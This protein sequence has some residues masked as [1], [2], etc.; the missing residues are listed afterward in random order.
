M[1]L[2]EYSWDE[3]IVTFITTQ[4]LHHAHTT[5]GFVRHVSTVVVKI[6]HPN[7]R[8]TTWV[9]T[10]ELI[11]CTGRWRSCTNQ[12]HYTSTVMLLLCNSKIWSSPI[13]VTDVGPGADPGVQVVLL[14]Y[15][16]PSPAVGC[17]YFPPGLQSP[18]QPKNVTVLWP[19]VIKLY[20]LMTEA[21]RCA[22]TTCTRL[23][24]GT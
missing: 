23:F 21:Y 17:H 11:R 20:C 6:T 15:F 19:V 13:L 8:Y 5:V 12:H 10:S 24:V 1:H 16:K 22:W 2:V 9:V 18:S 3:L 4:T 7:A 14:L